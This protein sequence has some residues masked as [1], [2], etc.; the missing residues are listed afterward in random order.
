[1]RE[2]GHQAR[3]VPSPTNGAGPAAAGPFDGAGEPSG[4]A[5][6]A[7]VGP[8]GT[9]PVEP[10]ADGRARPPTL[11]C[12]RVGYTWP[13]RAEP[14]FTGVG[15]TLATGQTLALLGPNG[16]GKSTLIGLLVGLQRPTTGRV[17][18]DDRPTTGWSPADLACMLAC[19]PQD[20][21]PT[22]RFTVQ[23]MLL[24]GRS[25]HLGI[26]GLPA[27]D[28]LHRVATVA[29][30]LELTALLDRPYTDLSGG[31]IKRVL[32]ARAF[33]QDTPILVLDEPDAHLDL[34]TQLRFLRM[35]REWV[36]GG[37]R[38][39]VFST[40][41]PEL[42]LRFSTHCLLIPGHDKPP[43][44]GKTSEVVNRGNLETLYGLS[45]EELR[46]S[47]GDLVLRFFA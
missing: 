7:P 18:V 17:L 4:A 44:F 25:P 47:A 36:A 10:P 3:A 35:V 43:L 30:Q 32:L 9:P 26:L 39:A 16:A 13:G 22:F 15:F 6:P 28:D 38:L 14:L 42:A 37:N 11:A 8:E 45:V 1:M 41:N 46:S 24:L 29:R 5:G 31:E 2:A 33:V 27:A 20:H 40:H 12:D 23:E 19:V 21:H 34:P